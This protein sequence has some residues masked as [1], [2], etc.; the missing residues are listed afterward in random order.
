MNDTDHELVGSDDEEPFQRKE[1]RAGPSSAASSSA[2][3][4][5]DKRKE[6]RAPAEPVIAEVADGRQQQFATGLEENQDHRQRC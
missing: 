4:I 3:A 5:G 1:L 6:L 2:P